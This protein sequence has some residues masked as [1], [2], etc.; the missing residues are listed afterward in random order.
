MSAIIFH[1]SLLNLSVCRS[2][3]FGPSMVKTQQVLGR[4]T[5]EISVLEQKEKVASYDPDFDSVIDRVVP[6]W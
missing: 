2:L 1:V 6:V 3:V 4:K 5:K